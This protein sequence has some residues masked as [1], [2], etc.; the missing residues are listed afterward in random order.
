MVDTQ[1]AHRVRDQRVLAALR[2]V[3]RHKFVAALRQQSAYADTPL[4]IGHGQTISQPY[5]VALMTE[6]LHIEPGEKV[7]EIGTGSG[8]Q[9]AVLNELTPY[10]FTIEIVQP[11]YKQVVQRFAELGHRT[12]QAR[13]ADGYDGWP[14]EAPFD[15]IIVTCAAGHVPPPLWEQLK[16]GG[17]M[18]IP[19]GGVHDI[20]RLVVLTK[21]NDGRRRSENVL[22]VRFVPM[23]GRSQ[24]Q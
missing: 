17:R 13:R 16:S 22:P 5:I 24:E 23:T 11:L 18:V 12:I 14:E 20:Q 10:V 21:L 2:S 1:I 3:P 19:L 7:L 15:A 9:A 8:Y 4:P 6:L